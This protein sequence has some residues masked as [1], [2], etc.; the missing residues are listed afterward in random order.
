VVTNDV[1]QFAIRQTIAGQMLVN[2]YHV[3]QEN[4]TGDLNQAEAQEIAD[5]LKEACRGRQHS[6][7]S[8]VTWSARQVRG[9]G[10]VRDAEDCSITGGSLFEGTF[11]GTLTGAQTANGEALPP[12]DAQVVT[13]LTGNAGRSKRGRLYLGGLPENAQNAGTWLSTWV[14]DLQT[15]MDA[16]LISFSAGGEDANIMR[17]RLCVWSETLAS[18]CKPQANPPF[19]RVNVQP[20]NPSLA[21]ADVIAYKVRS[22]VR[23]Q[24]R[25]QVGVGI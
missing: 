1:H 10:V 23:A 20:G 9:A 5:R 24:R 7:L 25:R 11:T 2:T 14:T 22:E 21:S 6:A 16:L 3:R 8:Y 18:G 15:A 19:T 17:Y 13:A 12:Q 4:V